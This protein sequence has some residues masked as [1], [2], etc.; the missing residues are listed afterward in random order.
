MP[1]PPSYPVIS[2][3]FRDVVEPFRSEQDNYKRKSAPKIN[4]SNKKLKDKLTDHQGS[5]NK[6]QKQQQEELQG[7][8][9]I[10]SNCIFYY[11]F[12]MR[13]QL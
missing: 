6:E 7:G 4:E 11:H 12:W 1:L 3:V 2:P 9:K 8:K 10:L 5:H 13:K